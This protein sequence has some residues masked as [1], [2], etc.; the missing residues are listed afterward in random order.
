M[1]LHDRMVCSIEEPKIQWRLLAEPD[2]TF[3]KAFELA[4]ASESA[5]KNAKDLQATKLPQ[6][7]VNRVQSKRRKTQG[8]RLLIQICRMPQVW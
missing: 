3:D 4:V 6:A 7:S 5:D 8:N 2:L 1:R